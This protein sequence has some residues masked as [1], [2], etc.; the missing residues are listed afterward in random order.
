MEFIIKHDT[1]LEQQFGIPIDVTSF[2]SSIEGVQA[3]LLKD[4]DGILEILVTLDKVDDKY[5]DS[6]SLV[7]YLGAM[8]GAE[9]AKRL[10]NNI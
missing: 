3:R 7:F 6:H 9:L 2:L 8:L 4:I 10:Y 5:K 1:R